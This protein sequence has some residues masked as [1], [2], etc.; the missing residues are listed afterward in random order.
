[1]MLP[2]NITKNNALSAGICNIKNVKQLRQCN[3]AK[4]GKERVYF[5]LIN[6]LEYAPA[7][8]Y[9]MTVNS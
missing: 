2:K 3:V 7:I 5:C 8:R 4:S 6:T 9:I 1:M